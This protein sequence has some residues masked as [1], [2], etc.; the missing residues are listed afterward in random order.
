MRHRKLRSKLGRSTGPR[1]ALLSG[2]VCAFIRERRIST[3]QA[4]ARAAARLAERM[5]TLAKRGTLAC[6]R[7]AL[8]ILRQE[9]AVKLFFAEI[10][11]QCQDRSGG[12]TRLIKSAYRRGD[13]AALA[14]LEWVNLRPL[15]KKKKPV[16][17]EQ[18]ALAA[19]AGSK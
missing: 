8:M 11:P 18:A 7:R 5:V 16:A 4:K 10:A 12:Y 15:D 3:T 1:Q 6:R 14:L 9:S 13:G 17:K 19:P 2:L